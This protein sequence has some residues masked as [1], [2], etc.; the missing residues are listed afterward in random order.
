M[1]SSLKDKLIINIRSPFLRKM[2]ADY[3]SVKH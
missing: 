1:N 2:E 3:I